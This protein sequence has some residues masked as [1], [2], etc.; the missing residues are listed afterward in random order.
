MRA[1][2]LLEPQRG[3]YAR[4]I[5]ATGA[6]AVVIVAFAT[7]AAPGWQIIVAGIALGLVSTQLG[8]IGHD[9]GHRQVTRSKRSIYLGDQSAVD[10][11]SE[12]LLEPAQ[13]G[14]RR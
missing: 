4:K 6:A 3:Y 1:A 2:G 12:E 10:V 14:F 5:L 11:L 13:R 8:L 7:I 9:L